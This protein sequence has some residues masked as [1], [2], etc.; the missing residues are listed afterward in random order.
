M[1]ALAPISTQVSL[2]PDELREHEAASIALD[3]AL[4]RLDVATKQYA[5]VVSD[6]AVTLQSAVDSYNTAAATATRLSQRFSAN[7]P[8]LIVTRPDEIEFTHPPEVPFTTGWAVQD[9][10]NFAD[11]ARALEEA[12]G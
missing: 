2:T 8:A 10:R 1:N 12:N 6:A 11:I 5:R 3:V 4:A 7:Q 9:A